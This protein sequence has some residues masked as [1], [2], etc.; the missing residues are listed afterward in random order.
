[1]SEIFFKK[2]FKSQAPIPFGHYEDC[3]FLQCDF[4]NAKFA[5]FVFENCRFAGCN[6]SLINVSQ[7]AFRE[8]QFADCKMLGVPF[9][10]SN[11]VGFSVYF[12][13][14]NLSNSSFFKI[15]AIATKFV[16]CRLHEV[17]FGQADLRKSVFY[18][19][20]LSQAR[21]DRTNLEEVDFSTSYNYTLIPENNKIKKAV[22]S[23]HGLPGLLAQHNIKI[24]N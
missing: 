18:E 20:D 24:L 10:Q 12:E 19:C 14:C 11:G 2:T 13:N 1:M 6:L 8:V 17:D 5:G 4:S 3:T 9:D 15:K 22:F 23:L 21:F 16:K 7:A